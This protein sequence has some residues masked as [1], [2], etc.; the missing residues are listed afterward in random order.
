MIKQ[1]YRFLSILIVSNLI[2]AQGVSA[3]EQPNVTK[4][5][6]CPSVC[7]N[8]IKTQKTIKEKLFGVKKPCDN[9]STVIQKPKPI[10]NHPACVTKYGVYF[11]DDVFGTYPPENKPVDKKD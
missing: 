6:D 9:Q 11:P 1:I 3:K 7:Q 2:L 10:D 5:K 4:S 8:K